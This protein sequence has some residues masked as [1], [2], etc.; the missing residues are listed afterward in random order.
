MLLWRKATIAAATA[1]AS[2]A[3]ATGACCRRPG[4]PGDREAKERQ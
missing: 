1:S 3:V 4:H 2:A